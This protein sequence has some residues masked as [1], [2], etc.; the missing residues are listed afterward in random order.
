MRTAMH[1][2]FRTAVAVLLVA[3]AAGAAAALT[4]Q[5]VERK[6]PRMSTIHIEKCDKRDDGLY[7]TGEMACV[8]SVYNMMYLSD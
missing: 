2:L 6:Y 1:G 4:L 3:P 8:R 7:D 5:Q